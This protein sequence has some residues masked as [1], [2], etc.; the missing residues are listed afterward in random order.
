MIRQIKPVSAEVEYCIAPWYLRMR[1]WIAGR[2][3][4]W[5]RSFEFLAL[6]CPEQANPWWRR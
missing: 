4:C 3:W 5:S 6:E 1:W 2:L